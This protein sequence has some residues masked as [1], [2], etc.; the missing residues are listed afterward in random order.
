[1]DKFFKKLKKS[2]K[3]YT[4]IELLLYITILG[5]VLIIV[6]DLLFKS[7]EAS[8]Q[9]RERN[10]LEANA[11][12]IFERIKYDIRS[13]TSISVPTTLGETSNYLSLIR[14]GQTITYTKV[15]NSLNLSNG[16]SSDNL[17]SNAVIVENITFQKL[18]SKL[19]EQGGKQTLKINLTLTNPAQ[20]KQGILSKSWTTT[21]GLR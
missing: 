9:F 19:E 13:A 20:T 16:V 15:S 11:S 12:L 5:I 8:V 10:E 4:L 17:S 21:S 2:A 3:G 7:L 1:M 6:I 18:G 14:N